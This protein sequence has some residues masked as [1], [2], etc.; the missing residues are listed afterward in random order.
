MGMSPVHFR[1]WRLSSKDASGL[2][3]VAAA[4]NIDY[5]I[6]V[7]TKKILSGI[8][9]MQYPSYEFED[10]NFYIQWVQSWWVVAGLWNGL[11][12][13]IYLSMKLLLTWISEFVLLSQCFMHLQDVILSQH[14]VA[15]ARRQF[16]IHGSL[17][18]S[19]QG[20]W[21]V[22]VDANQDQWSDY[23]NIGAICGAASW[24]YECT[25]TMEILQWMLMIAENICLHRRPGALKT[26]H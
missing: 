9:L 1:W 10:S 8:S 20:I 23:G 19:H 6:S 2:F 24:S 11:M 4:D 18:W 15:E 17:C 26:D 22:T 7:A 12:L 3:T 13:G 14:F 5:S 25:T 16:G 21:R